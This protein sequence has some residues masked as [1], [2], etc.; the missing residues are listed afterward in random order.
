M[1]IINKINI[2]NRETHIN[3]HF[4]QKSHVKEFANEHGFYNW[5]LINKGSK[6]GYSHIDDNVLYKPFSNDYFYTLELEIAMNSIE[7]EAKTYI[8]NIIESCDQGKG[9]V[10]FNGV[11]YLVLKCYILLSIIR[12]DSFRKYIADKSKHEIDYCYNDHIKPQ[13]VQEILMWDI[14]KKYNSITDKYMN[15]IQE[16]K[17]YFSQFDNNNLLGLNDEKYDATISLIKELGFKLFFIMFVSELFISRF[18]DKRLFLTGTTYASSMT[19]NDSEVLYF[20]ISPQYMICCYV[21][22]G[23]KS[24]IRD[25]DSCLNVE[26]DNKSSS[27]FNKLISKY[28]PLLVQDRSVES[29]QK[30]YEEKIDKYKLEQISITIRIINSNWESQ[31][32]INLLLLKNAIGEVVLFQ[33]KDDLIQSLQELE[34]FDDKLHFDFDLEIEKNLYKGDN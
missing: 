6:F 25:F 3:N 14:I 30:W 26:L 16:S 27:Q 28:C 8:N 10:N 21:P 13:E 32:I 5:I 33:N 1:Q 9:D 4:V 17:I 7:S 18:E 15:P 12:T 11:K 34:K 29:V 2:D 23:C 24:Q 31:N 19:S 22:L 20:P